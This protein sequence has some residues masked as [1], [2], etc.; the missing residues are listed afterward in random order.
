[1]DGVMVVTDDERGWRNEAGRLFQRRKERS[2]I[3]REEDEGG[4][5]MVDERWRTSAV[6]CCRDTGNML[7]ATSNMLLVDGNMLSVSRQHVSLCIQQQTV[8]VGRTFESVCLSVCLFVRSKTQ[9]Q[10][11]PKCSN[12]VQVTLGYATWYGFG[13]KGQRSRSGLGFGLTAIRRGFELY[14]CQVSS[15]CLNS[16]AL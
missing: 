6:T 16:A 10:K 3:L 9:K 7:P 1:M 12:L 4:W 15:Y 11:I 2:V 8:G 14:E 13:L 5:A